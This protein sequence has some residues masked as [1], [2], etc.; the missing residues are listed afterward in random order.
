MVKC[1]IACCSSFYY[2]KL[3]KRIEISNTYLTASTPRSHK[4]GLKSGVVK[5]VS[6]P[7]SK[8]VNEYVTR[9]LPGPSPKNVK[10]SIDLCAMDC[11]R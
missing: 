10:V 3:D 6:G 7:L 9:V 8:R 4:A 2:A 11:A 5:W 1:W